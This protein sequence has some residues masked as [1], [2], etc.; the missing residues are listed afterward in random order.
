MHVRGLLADEAWS[1]AHCNSARDFTRNRHM[2]FA[3]TLL[4]VL[5]KSAKSIQLHLNEF[6]AQWL[7][8]AWGR[9]TPGA[10]TRA[11]AKLS[12]RAFSELNEQAVLEEFYQP[13]NPQQTWCGHRLLATDGSEVHLPEAEEIGTCFGWMEPRHKQGA[14]GEPYIL[15]R[16]SVLSDV[17]N[18]LVLHGVLKS[19]LRGRNRMGRAAPG[20]H[21]S[22]A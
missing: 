16:V 10:W 15:G 21:P 18:R 4:L 17:H 12:P 2:N 11:R 8:Q 14:C 5:Q 22:R 3:A 13:D 20:P 1:R 6:F 9:P 19:L 7:P